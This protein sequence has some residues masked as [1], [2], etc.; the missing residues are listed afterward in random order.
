M[1]YF[2]G[3]SICIKSDG[4]HFINTERLTIDTYIVRAIF[5]LSKG[6]LRLFW[7]T[8]PSK[9]Y[10]FDDIWVLFFLSCFVFYDIKKVINFQDFSKNC[11]FYFKKKPNFEKQTY[12]KLKIHWSLVAQ[13]ISFFLSKKKGIFYW[14]MESAKRKCR[15]F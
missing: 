14:S 15:K 1:T 8:H 2:L 9:P 7:T 12:Q 4:S 6:A 3:N 11:N 10:F 5:I 13:L